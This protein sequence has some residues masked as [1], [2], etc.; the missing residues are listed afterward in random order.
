M[1]ALAA[2]SIRRLSIWLTSMPVSTFS[3]ESGAV[4]DG[5]VSG[6]L[7]EKTTPPVSVTLIVLA[8]VAAITWALTLALPELRD[9]Y[10]KQVS[11]FAGLFEGRQANRGKGRN[12]AE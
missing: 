2:L 4:D 5:S 6:G 10:E 9:E 8:G 1:P 7:F 11:H 12:R 3:G